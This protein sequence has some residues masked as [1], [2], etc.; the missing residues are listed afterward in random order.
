MERKDPKELQR[1]QKFW[2]HYHK[3]NCLFYFIL[4]YIYIYISYPILGPYTCGAGRRGHGVG[5]PGRSSNGPGA[6][7][8][9]TQMA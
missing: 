6:G 4:L 2:K 7:E 8:G 3:Y 5:A 9:A 1:F